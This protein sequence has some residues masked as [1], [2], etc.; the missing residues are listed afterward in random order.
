MNID[1]VSIVAAASLIIPTA[2]SVVLWVSN[3]AKT[4]RIAQLENC[5]F[6]LSELLSDEKEAREEDQ[7][8]QQAYIDHLEGKHEADIQSQQQAYRDLQSKL[9]DLS[10]NPLGETPDDELAVIVKR[11]LTKRVKGYRQATLPW[12]NHAHKLATQV[13]GACFRVVDHCKRGHGEFQ[14][15]GPYHAPAADAASLEVTLNA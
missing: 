9:Y 1:L 14:A 13:G 12:G 15:F 8:H 10:E 3:K 5:K 7:R 6:S 11:E 2:A 4:R